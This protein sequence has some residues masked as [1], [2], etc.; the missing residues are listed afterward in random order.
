[1]S[2]NGAWRPERPAQSATPVQT[3]NQA[4]PAGIAAIRRPCIG[5]LANHIILQPNKAEAG[6]ADVTSAAVGKTQTPRQPQQQCEPSHLS[7]AVAATQ[8]FEGT[9]RLTPQ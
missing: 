2:S 1:M 3:V 9:F 8:A 5:R 4:T 7:N 6:S